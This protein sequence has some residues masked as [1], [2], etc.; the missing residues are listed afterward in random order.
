MRQDTPKPPTS[1]E[2]MRDLMTDLQEHM[3]DPND[4]IDLEEDKAATEEPA[5]DQAPKAEEEKKEESKEVTASSGTSENAAASASNAQEASVSAEQT[6]STSTAFD[7][8]PE[9]EAEE[10]T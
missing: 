3:N 9:N 5:K 2:A 6:A 7:H 1:E 4:A 8:E 10:S